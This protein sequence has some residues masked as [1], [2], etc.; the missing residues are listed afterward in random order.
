[1][2]RYVHKG[3]GTQADDSMVKSTQLHLVLFI[4]IYI[5]KSS[6][7]VED[8]LGTIGEAITASN[9]WPAFRGLAV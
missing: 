4:V 2:C 1:M 8:S 3:V 6:A 9:E 7:Y 5:G